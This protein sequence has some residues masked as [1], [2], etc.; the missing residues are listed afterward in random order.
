MALFD[1]VIKGVLGGGGLARPVAI[2]IGALLLRR[3]FTPGENAQTAAP[4]SMPDMGQ[5]EQAGGGLLGGLNDLMARFK[6]AGQQQTM[7]S[8]IGT[9]QN[10]PI[11]PGQLGSTIGQQTIGDLARQSGISEQ[12]LLNA[13][14]KSL[15][16]VI[17]GL[18][19]HGRLPTPG[20]ISGR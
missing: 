16:G 20:E 5:A 14:A 19:P 3:M 11:D 18:T 9:G 12:D 6:N 13:L 8:W 2:A 15:P 4:S 10:Q 17:D 1:D 7:E